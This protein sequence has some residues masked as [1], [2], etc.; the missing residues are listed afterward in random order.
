MSAGEERALLAACR[1][2][3][4]AVSGRAPVG[5]LS[6][7][8]SESRDT[9][10]LLVEEG[11]RYTLNWCHDDQPVAMHT[12]AGPLWS[13]PYPQELNDIPAIAVRRTAADTFADMIVDNFDEMLAQSRTQPL[14]M[15][16]GAAR[17]Y[18]AQPAQA[19]TRGAAGSPRHAQGDDRPRVICRRRRRGLVQ[20]PRRLLHLCADAAVLHHATQ[21][22]WTH[23]GAATRGYQVS[24]A[25]AV[26]RRA[27]DYSD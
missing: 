2:R 14:V 8:I 25:C 5:W 19:G 23:R 13:V 4:A 18:R 15:G 10:D 20:H 9:P 6:P 7:W 26:R 24:A 11:Y 3:L 27:G 21:M 16:G 1:E 22:A 17:L 12:R